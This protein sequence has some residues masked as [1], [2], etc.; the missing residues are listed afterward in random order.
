MAAL[1]SIAATDN[2]EA[3]PLVA[4]VLDRGGTTAVLDE[5]LKT[6]AKLKASSLSVAIA[7]YVQHRSEEI[8]RAAVRT[9]LKTK[10]PV[11]AEALEKGLRSSDAAVRGTSA[12]GLGAL[13]VHDALDDLFAAF[14]HGVAEAAAAIG[15]L[16]R[17]EECEKFAERTGRVAFDV[18]VT[19]FDQILFRPAEEIPD[20]EKIR[21]VGRLRELGTPEVS[22]YLADVGDRWPKDWSKK[23]KQAVDSAAHAIGGG[24]KK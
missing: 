22:K 14:D 15:Q 6:A 1:T 7:P 24:S 19:G 18:M 23:V 13:G 16:C 20:E 2:A 10:G 5:A 12:T 17:P 4:G 3:A 11:A 9:L 21:L 8:R